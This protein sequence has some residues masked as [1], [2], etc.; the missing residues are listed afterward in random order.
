MALF[1]FHCL[2]FTFGHFLGKSLFAMLTDVAGYKLD[3]PI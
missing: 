3:D 1:P 2:T